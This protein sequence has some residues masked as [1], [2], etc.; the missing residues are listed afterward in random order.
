M[1]SWP[2]ISPSEM[3]RSDWKKKTKKKKEERVAARQDAQEIE[4]CRT[5]SRQ[6]RERWQWQRGF[7]GTEA[8]QPKK[9]SRSPSKGE[10][11]EAAN[12]RTRS[13][14]LALA[15]AHFRFP[16]WA[17]QFLHVMRCNFCWPISGPI[18]AFEILS[19]VKRPPSWIAK[20]PNLW[21][22]YGAIELSTGPLP[23]RHAPEHRARSSHRAPE[24][25]RPPR[26][27]QGHRMS[28]IAGQ[29]PLSV[30][31]GVLCME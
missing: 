9:I 15:E 26:V 12:K 14:H 6:T 23:A 31:G 30:W 24:S 22:R 21:H 1:G 25:R 29:I 7:P 13:Q 19:P 2:G 18:A 5:G 8:R 10:H 16:S 20:M 17:F 3:R 28:P 4:G 27:I 11:G